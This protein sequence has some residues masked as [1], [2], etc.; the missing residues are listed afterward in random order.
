MSRLRH[1]AVGSSL[2]L[3]P[4]HS[5]ETA[6][7]WWLPGVGVC[8]WTFFVWVNVHNLKD[9]SDVF[10]ESVLLIVFM[11]S[12][13]AHNIITSSM[14]H[15]LFPL[16]HRC[17][18]YLWWW[19]KASRHRPVVKIAS[20]THRHKKN[21][22]QFNYLNICLFVVQT[23][24]RP[25]VKETINSTWRNA[26]LTKVRSVCLRHH[27]LKAALNKGHTSEVLCIY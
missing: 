3:I 14:Q 7:Q 1:L 22:K 15:E 27:L 12:F 18:V 11:T 10:I 13:C 26:Q 25:E 17:A 6:S 20:N 19:H 5:S 2:L 24:E 21:Q 4:L 9:E 16:R 8:V 23:A